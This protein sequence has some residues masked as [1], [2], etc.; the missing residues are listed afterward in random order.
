MSPR[1]SVIIP[2]YNTAEVV[3]DTLDSVF[4]QT[5]TDFE[6][7]LIDDESPD[8]ARL[9][10]V[11]APYRDK[12]HYI[13]TRNQGPAAARNTGIRAAR[14]ELIAM[15]DSDDLWTPDYLAYQVGQLDADPSADIVYPNAVVFGVGESGRRLAMEPSRPQPEVTF[16]RLVTEECSVVVSVL[17]RKA[18]LERAGLFDEQFRWCEDFDLWLRCL[19]AHSRIV[20]H[21]KVL[22]RYR[23]RPGSLSWDQARMAAHAAKVLRKMQHTVPL[24]EAERGAIEA[25]LRQLDALQS[26]NEGR[27][28]FFAG[29]Y[30]AAREK[31]QA[32]DRYLNSKRIK[33]LLLLLRAAPR[34]AQR[35]LVWR[36]P[37]MSGR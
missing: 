12:L 28:A 14:G 6:V 21:H 17:A 31:L 11:L 35:A 9:E 32:A 19:K 18:A 1:V 22:L 2:Y 10:R 20:Y 26:Y 13:R 5:Y 3:A 36:H 27:Q 34:L 33:L 8:S 4:A 23:R 24:T 29:D 30:G 15:I 7:I 16:T 37:E 25:K